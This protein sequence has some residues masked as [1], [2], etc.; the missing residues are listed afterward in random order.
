M[1]DLENCVI[2]GSSENL[3]TSMTITVD[4]KKIEVSICDEDADD[5]T[6]KR[7]KQCY[8]DKQAQIEEVLAK[9]KALG[10]T[11]PPALLVCPDVSMSQNLALTAE[12]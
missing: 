2:C 11:V 4:G 7:I 12:K 6:P 9:A 10:L 5:V 8:A 3:N 1:L